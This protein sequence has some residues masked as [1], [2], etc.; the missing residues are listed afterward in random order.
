MSHESVWMTPESFVERFWDKPHFVG[1][2]IELRNRDNWQRDIELARRLQAG[3]VMPYNELTQRFDFLW[4]ESIAGVMT[5]EDYAKRKVADSFSVS[6]WP[7]IDKKLDLAF[8]PQSAEHSA[9]M[10]WLYLAHQGMA[11]EAWIESDKPTGYTINGYGYWRSSRYYDFI[12]G[13]R[14]LESDSMDSVDENIID[15]R[16]IIISTPDDLLFMR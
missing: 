11:K 4:A 15:G 8:I 12:V 5:R 14:L 10:S 2:V 16:L 6:P 13:L 1:S 7:I 3:E 9:V